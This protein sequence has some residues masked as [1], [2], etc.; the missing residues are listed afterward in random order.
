MCGIHVLFRGLWLSHMVENW[1]YFQKFYYLANS[2][3]PRFQT[4]ILIC[5]ILRN[6]SAM[7]YSSKMSL[8]QI[9]I[10]FSKETM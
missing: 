2:F 4:E 9:Q 6:R 10:D 7:N 3:F 1:K 8:M 5:L